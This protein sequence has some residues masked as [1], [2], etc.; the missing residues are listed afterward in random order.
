MAGPPQSVMKP[1]VK[2]S[3]CAAQPKAP[4]ACAQGAQI[5]P[6]RGFKAGQRQC[7]LV[8]W[9]RTVR[10]LLVQGVV[11]AAMPFTNLFPNLARAVICVMLSVLWLLAA[12]SALSSTAWPPP[13]VTGSSLYGHRGQA[14]S[15]C[16][17]QAH[18]APHTWRSMELL[19]RQSTYAST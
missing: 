3:N 7:S 14:N 2:A 9:V 1:R 13:G 19:S 12:P 5:A 8:G 17:V 15:A 6:V 16:K 18:A 4:L 11:D 10:W